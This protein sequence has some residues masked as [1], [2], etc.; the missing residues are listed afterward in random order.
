MEQVFGLAVKM[1]DKILSSPIAV[2]PQ[3]QIPIPAPC[4]CTAWEAAVLAQGDGSL[5]SV[6][7]S[8]IVVQALSIC[9]VGCCKHFKC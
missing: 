1:L 3:L 2:Q 8:W 9:S 4:H 6:W 5:P 7:G